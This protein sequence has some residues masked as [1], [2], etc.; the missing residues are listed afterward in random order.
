MLRLYKGQWA[1]INECRK[2]EDVLI[3][4]K[5]LVLNRIVGE[6]RGDVSYRWFTVTY[7]QSTELERANERKEGKWSSERYFAFK[8]A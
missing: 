7:F 8:V 3:K 4:E 1:I 6:G 5:I 2:S